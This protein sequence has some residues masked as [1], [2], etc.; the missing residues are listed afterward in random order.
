[1][2]LVKKRGKTGR[3]ALILQSCPQENGA[4]ALA[5]VLSAFGKSVPMGE[6]TGRPMASAADIVEAARSLG[7]RAQGYQMSW[8]ELRRAPLPLIAH[9]RFRSFVVVTGFRGDKVLVHSPEEGSLALSRRAFEAGFTGVALCFAA[10]EA[11]GL[12]GGETAGASLWE[13]PAAPVLLGAAQ[14]FITAC[15]VLLAVRFRGVAALL[16]SPQAEGA[17]AL[18]LELGGLLLLQGAAA[19]FQVWLIGRCRRLRRMEDIRAFRERLAGENA[20]FLRKTSRL[21]LD[22]AARDQAARSAAMAREAVC[23]L[24][25]ISGGICLCVMAAQVP[26]AA[27]AAL[28]PAAAFALACLGRRER[29]YSEDKLR[30]REQVLGEDLAARDLEDWEDLRLRGEDGARF[31]RWAGETGGAFRPAE[32]ETQRMLWYA[33]AA[34]L[35]LAVLCVCLLE[36]IAGMAD[37][38]DL[39]GCM[40]LAAA[41]AASLGSLPC[42]LAERAAARRCGESAGLVFRRTEEARSAAAAAAP[43]SVLTVQNASVRPAGAG[44]TVKD[45]SFTVRKGEVLVVAGEPEILAALAAMVSGM[46][47]PL[48]GELYLDSRAAG[49]LSEEALCGSIALLGV[50]LPYPRGT[51][52]E[53]IAAGLRDITD[54]AVMEA[55]SDA[56]L[57]QRILGRAGRYD[58]PVSTLSEG[59]RILLEFARAFARG[60]PFLVCRG[61]TGVLDPETEDRLIRNIRRRGVGAVL[62]TEDRTLLR[63]GDIVYRI[64]GGRTALR[65]RAELVEEV[66]SLV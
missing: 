34:V 44:E 9:W 66:D 15:Y 53:N 20:A 31:Q 22:E 26:G 36:M 29:L 47:R 41:A 14:L 60:T 1:M 30:S 50:G 8:G 52:R 10:E 65:E 17:L 33:G 27:A 6:L 28:L 63:K 32:M 56:L 4:A 23:A 42:L 37:T 25:L 62:L 61:L 51:V 48:Q 49:D 38:Q 18:C 54:Y 3:A 64:E 55:A 45:I 16:A 43:A 35:L 24:Q 40:A 46:E 7:V 21:R 39:L 11:E 59:E 2:D 5:M 12:T 13:G 58:T 57:H 19:V